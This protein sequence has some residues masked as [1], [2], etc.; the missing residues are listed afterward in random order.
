MANLLGFENEYDILNQKSK[1]C[2][3]FIIIIELHLNQLWFI[4]KDVSFLLLIIHLLMFFIL[5]SRG[6]WK[7]VY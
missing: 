3:T 4:K 7:M 5:D 1:V 6:N 2:I